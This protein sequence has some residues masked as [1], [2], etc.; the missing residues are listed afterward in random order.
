MPELKEYE[1]LFLKADKAAR[2]A[3]DP[4]ARQQAE[5]D[6]RM[7]LGE[8]DR[9]K[10]APAPSSIPTATTRYDISGAPQARIEAPGLGTAMR[11]TAVSATGGIAGQAIG[12]A[13]APGVGTVIGGGI[14]SG[15]AN[16][17]NQLTRMAKDPAYKFQFGE[18]MADVGTGMVPGG[19]LASAGLRPIGREALKGGATALAGAET[20][21]LIDRGQALSAEQAAK[22]VGLGGTTGGAA[23]RL[24][25]G[26]P[27]TRQVLAEQQ[28]GRSRTSVTTDEGA[29]L[30]LRAAPADIQRDQGGGGFVSRQ[31]SSLAGREALDFEVRG[32]NQQA[33]NSAV[34]TQLGV[35]P[36]VDVTVDTLRAIR[37]REGQV[38]GQFATIAQ[39]ARTQ[40]AELD[41]QRQVIETLDPTYARQRGMV[42]ADELRNFDNSTQ[43]GR[44][45]MDAAINSDPVELRRIRGEAQGLMD[46]YYASGGKNVDAQTRAFQLRQQ[47]DQIEDAMEQTARAIGQP[48]LADDLVAARRRIAQSYDAE[49]ALNVGTGDFDARVFGRKVDQGK[50]LSG[51][52]ATIG[53]FQQAYKKAFGDPGA[54]RPAGISKLGVMGKLLAGGATYGATQSAPIAA[55]TAFAP[56]IAGGLAR[57]RLLSESAQESAREAIRPRPRRGGPLSSVA[58]R[59]AGQEAGETAAEGPVLTQAAVDFLIKN[60]DTAAEFDRKYGEGL[61]R[62]FLKANPR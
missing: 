46:A 17:S 40:L 5:S 41:R 57:S 45:Q 44:Q 29:S 25:A 38:Y 4:A 47:A 15:L 6:A 28:A 24:Q 9:L 31:M 52:M 34:K 32:Q 16:L 27:V 58:T 18:L 12:T 55:A 60:P 3:T 35:P 19:P 62:R 54:A 1:D 30:G 42:I 37:E 59:I 20:Q 7:F 43:A 50:P 53:R 61:A 14:G 10:K 21:S 22:A 51:N 39:D 26:S 11:E 48:N 2:E 8:I 23:Q 36:D 49:D 13:I 33:V 56:D